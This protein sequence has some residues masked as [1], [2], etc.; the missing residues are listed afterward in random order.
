MKKNRDKII[1]LNKQTRILAKRTSVLKKKKRRM[2]TKSILKNLLILNKNSCRV[3]MKRSPNK[4]PRLIKINL[5][6]ILSW[7][8]TRRTKKSASHVGR[9]KLKPIWQWIIWLSKHNTALIAIQS[10][11]IYLIPLS[12]KVIRFLIQQSMLLKKFT[13]FLRNFCL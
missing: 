6:T 10:L 5:N 4:R 7:S 3:M 2:K 9:R 8:L 12:L 11:K 13:N 1:N